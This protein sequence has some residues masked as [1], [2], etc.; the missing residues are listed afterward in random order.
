MTDED[1]RAAER[2]SRADAEDFEAFRRWR[3]AAAR[4]GTLLPGADPGEKTAAELVTEMESMQRRWY[5]SMHRGHDLNDVR[6]DR[7]KRLKFRAL[8]DH[9]ECLRRFVR[10]FR[11]W[12]RV[13]GRRAE[14]D[15]H[16]YGPADRFPKE[17]RV[18]ETSRLFSPSDDAMMLMQH[19]V[20]SALGRRRR[21]LERMAALT[22]AGPG[23]RLAPAPP[24]GSSGST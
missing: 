17:R 20:P 24:P 12:L 2:A 11:V 15:A 21:R 18:L 14:W 23:L 7:A 13:T 6:G 3:A 19:Y 4:A 8:D 10:L 22:P 5:S 9:A 1:L 16:F